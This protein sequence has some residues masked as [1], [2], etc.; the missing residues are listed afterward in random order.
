MLKDQFESY[1]PLQTCPTLVI[2]PG[3]SGKVGFNE[4]IEAQGSIGCINCIS[5]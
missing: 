4:V 5:R 2:C 3:C 1:N